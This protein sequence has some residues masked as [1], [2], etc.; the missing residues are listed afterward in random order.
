MSLV[1]ARM[2]L[3]LRPVLICILNLS[4]PVLYTHLIRVNV[5]ELDCY[6]LPFIIAERCTYIKL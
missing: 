4:F 2:G 1:L 3:S 6:I 5:A